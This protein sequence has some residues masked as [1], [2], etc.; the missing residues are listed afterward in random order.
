LKVILPYMDDKTQKSMAI[1]IKFLELN[2]TIEYFKKHSSPLSGCMEREASPDPFKMCSEL[3]PYCTESERK[4]I[5]QIRGVFQSMEM[6]K[7]MSRTMEMMKDF[8]PDLSSFGNA[9]SN[10]ADSA[11]PQG[12]DNSGGGFDMMNML[13]NM[14]T[15][16]EKQMYEMFG[17]NLNAE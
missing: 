12:D 3:L 10:E 13:M 9:F 11:S 4:Q 6:Y 1:Y 5:E 16:E 14:L 7:E 8:M 17:G 15:P 2:Y